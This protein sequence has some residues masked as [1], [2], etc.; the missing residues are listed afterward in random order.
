[1]GEKIMGGTPG[2]KKRWA[3]L[4]G[5]DIGIEGDPYLD[6][7]RIV[8]TP[9]FG[10]YLH[11]IHRP[12]NDRYPHDHPWTF[13]SFVLA[14]GYTEQ[15]WPDKANPVRHSTRERRRWSFAQMNRKAAHMITGLDGPLWTLVFTG[16]RRAE[17]GFWEDGTFVSWRNYAQSPATYTKSSYGTGNQ[18]HRLLRQVLSDALPESCTLQMLWQNMTMQIDEMPERETISRWLHQDAEDGLVTQGDG[19]W[20]ATEALRELVTT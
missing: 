17:W 11:H 14:G 9:W 18:A 2:A 13:W 15:L 12:D 7:L 10:V 4:E 16:P 3:F 1:M 19:Y 6:R 5:F 20:R 8:Q